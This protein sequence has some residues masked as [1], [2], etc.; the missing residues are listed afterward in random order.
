MRTIS[1]ILYFLSQHS[2][3]SL[4]VIVLV[5]TF[6]AAAISAWRRNGAWHLLIIPGL[7]FGMINVFT[8]HIANALFLNAFGE[9]GSA[10]VTY[11][12][13]TSSQLNDQN[14]WAYDAVV[15]T[16]DGKDV[17]TKFTTMSASIY[18]VRNEIL[19]PPLG[20][21]FVVKYIPG[22]ARNIAIMS[23][24][25]DYGRRL[26]VDDDRGPVEKAAMQFAAS[27]N[28]PAFVAEYRTALT[29]FLTKHRQ[30]AD[31]ALVRDYQ[32]RL[33]ALTP[34]PAAAR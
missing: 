31:P 32:A 23:D 2:L 28:N 21:R 9:V 15:K 8:A 25:S 29:T 11:Q 3:L 26:V 13:E 24:Q 1:A 7:V 20:E 33:D 17:V 19:I 10:V 18:P 5:S 30:D 4:P 16:A 34:S 22:F 12:R 6:I 14:I 27:P